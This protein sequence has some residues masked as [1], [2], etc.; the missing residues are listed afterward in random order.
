[1]EA[2]KQISTRVLKTAIYQMIYNSQYLDNTRYL[3]LKKGIELHPAMDWF[4]HFGG[5]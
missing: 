4:E 5:N 1:M 2:A 3:D